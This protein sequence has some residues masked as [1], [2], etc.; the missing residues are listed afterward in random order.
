MIIAGGIL[1]VHNTTTL[2]ALNPYSNNDQ[3]LWKL[4]THD[5][6]LTCAACTRAAMV[7]SST[8]KTLH[9]SVRGKLSTIYVGEGKRLSDVKIIRECVI[10]EGLVAGLYPKLLRIKVRPENEF[11]FIVSFAD[12]TIFCHDQDTKEYMWKRGTIASAPPFMYNLLYVPSSYL[13]IIGFQGGVDFT[14]LK[15]RTTHHITLKEEKS[16]IPDQWSLVK[17]G[18]VSLM[19]SHGKLIAACEG[20]LYVIEYLEHIPYILSKWDYSEVFGPSMIAFPYLDLPELVSWTQDYQ[21]FIQ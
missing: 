15:T 13:I 7:Y 20:V 12:Q 6:H 4:P 16:K 18:Y 10:Y 8:H 21:F 19:E 11:E 9:I 5:F 14:N 3:I 2:F 17:N 1:F